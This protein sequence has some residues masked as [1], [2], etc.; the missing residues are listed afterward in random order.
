[1]ILPSNLQC[2]PPL[3]AAVVAGEAAVL[4]TP[5]EWLTVARLLQLTPRQRAVAELLCAEC[6]QREMARRLGLSMDTV[7]THLRA[8]YARLHVQSR[9]GVVVRLVLAE[10]EL[11]DLQRAALTR[12]SDVAPAIAERE[13]TAVAVGAASFP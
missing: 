9:V 1:M 11:A 4:F 6:S 3:R 12:G 5:E 13:E 10:R 8:L 7:R 2:Q